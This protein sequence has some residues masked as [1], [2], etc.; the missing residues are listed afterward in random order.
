MKILVTGGAGFIGSH[1]VDTFLAAGHEVAVVD[2]LSTGNRAWVNPRAKLHAVDLRSGR[3]AEVFA[4]ERP[5][6]VAH[7]AA[8][9][10]VSR[11]VTDPVFDAS[12]NVG[13]GLNLLDCCRRFGVH[14]MIYS[15]SGGAGYGDTDVLPTP[16]THP[17]LPMS[18]YGITKVAMELYVGAWTQIFGMSGISLRYANVY[19]PRQNHQ[20]EAGVVAIFCHRLLTDQAP[21]INGDGG[22]TRD[23]VYVGDVARANLLALER[24]DATGG[25]NIATGIETS[26]NDI[27]AGIKSAAGSSVAAQYGPARPGEQRRSCLD[28][29]LAERIFGWRPTVTLDE[30]LT[31]TY[32]FFRKELSR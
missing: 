7:L 26:V 31:R 9:A 14:R 12:V 11:S 2:N 30:G 5:E 19:G 4:A 27:Y 1:V 29:K 32:D 23:F 28:P 8:Q 25:I 15:S 21:V 17:S 13:G 6:V 20:G 24:S 10:A 3:L 18:P 22:Q 16:E